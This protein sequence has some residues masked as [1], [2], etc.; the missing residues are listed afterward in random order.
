MFI[1]YFLI[2]VLIKRFAINMVLCK[3]WLMS[4][5]PQTHDKFAS[6]HFALV[7]FTNFN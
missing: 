6:C 2:Q 7:K 4:T 5:K 1:L 3:I